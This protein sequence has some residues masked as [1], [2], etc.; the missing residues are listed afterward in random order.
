MISNESMRL[1]QNAIHVYNKRVAYTYLVGYRVN[2]NKPIQ[3]MEITIS[4]KNFWHL[5]GCELAGETSYDCLEKS[6]IYSRCLNNEDIKDLL[7]Y[8]HSAA[9]VGKK[10]KVLVNVF[11]FINHAKEIKICKA[12]DCP[13]AAMFRIGAG[14]IR[15]LIGYGNNKNIYYP[16]TAQDKSIFH[17][18]PNANDKIVFVLSKETGFQVYEKIEYEVSKGIVAS[19]ISSISDDVEISPQILKSAEETLK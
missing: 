15:G 17:I 9:D 7:D 18:N 4:E 8:T 10:C 1:I 16:K 3:T 12:E 11:D 13:E 6:K 19:L 14:N 5:A 2:K